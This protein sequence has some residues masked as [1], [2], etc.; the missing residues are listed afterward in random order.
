M[1]RYQLS[2][3]KMFSYQLPET[4]RYCFYNEEEPTR[5]DQTREHLSYVTLVIK[6]SKMTSRDPVATV[7]ENINS[8]ILKT[9]T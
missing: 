6:I 7:R 1:Y 4:C 2:M 9:L 5:D 3:R 8:K